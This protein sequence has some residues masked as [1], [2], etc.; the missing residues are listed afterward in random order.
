MKR[1]KEMVRTAT[2]CSFNPMVDDFI[3]ARF[4]FAD[5]TKRARTPA[6]AEAEAAAQKLVVPPPRTT[7]TGT[8]TGPRAWGVF[9]RGTPAGGSA[10]SA[11]DEAAAA[12]AAA[13]AP[14][15]TAGLPEWARKKLEQAQAA[16]AKRAPKAPQGSEQAGGQQGDEGKGK[17]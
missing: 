11:S 4:F 3:N 10:A 6:A 1:Y 13:A 5:A 8:A 17:Q 7:G 12:A 2:I 9:R 16:A 14:I 15:P